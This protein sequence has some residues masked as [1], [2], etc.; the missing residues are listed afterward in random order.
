MRRFLVLSFIALLGAALPASASERILSYN[1][2]IIV[3]KDGAFLVTETITVNAEGNQIRRGIFRDFPTVFADDNDREHK[4]GFE[5]ISVTRNGNPEPSTVEKGSRALNIRI[6]NA[7]HFLPHGRHTYEIKYRTTRQLRRFET[8]DEV[9]WNATGTQWAFPIDKARATITLPE[10][11]KIA[12]SIFFTGSFGEQGKN[13]R[14]VITSNG[15]SA[16]FETTQPLRPR[17]GLTAAIKFQKGLIPEL[18]Q[19]QEMRF[20]LQD[21]ISEIIAF[22]GLAVIFLYYMLMWLRVGRDPAKGTIVPRWDLPKE[23]SPALSHYIHHHSLKKQGFTALSAAALSLAVKGIVTLDNANDTLTITQTGKNASDKLPV[24]EALLLSRIK[25]AGGTFKINKSNGPAVQKM[26]SAFRSGME[27][28]HRGKFFKQNLGYAVLGIFLSICVFILALA[29]G[30]FDEEV[31]V[32]LVPAIM[33]GTVTTSLIV[34]LTKS[35]GS[36]LWSKVRKVFTLFFIVAIVG[37]IGGVLIS[38]WDFISLPMSLIL[39]LVTI[40]MVNILFFHLLGAPTQ[41]GQKH[42]GEIEGLKHYLSV[43]EEDRMNMLNSPEM[44]PQHYETLLPYAVA[45]GVEKPWSKAFQGWL[46]AAVAAGAAAA[47]AY[48]NRGPGWYNGTDFSTD[49]ISDTFGKIGD[50]MSNTMTSSLPAPKSSSSGF[51]GGGGSSGGGGGGGGG[52]G[53]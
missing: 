18:T 24:G 19:Q 1:S 9:Y 49:R 38:Q 6:G 4:V 21:Y 50:D 46:A 29:L 42:A 23:I 47:V 2:D 7:D 14:A 25:M 45:L 32:V 27:S 31:I 15:R 8:H 13:A 44:S 10:G 5:L 17:E 40:I 43:A 12:D 35:S 11:G 20:F 33:I 37:N 36:G 28:E 48:S 34:S 26:A 22:V 53:W 16:R 52:G 41:I 30:G 51:S 3:E 39:A